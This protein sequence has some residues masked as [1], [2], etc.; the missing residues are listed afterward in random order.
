[1]KTFASPSFFRVFDL[2]VGDTNPGFKQSRWSA[3]GVDFERE[4]HNFS[5]P[6]HEFTIE[7]FTLTK[8]GKRGWSLMV[9]KDYWW[10]GKESDAGRMPHWA[11]LKDGQRADVFAWFRDQELL[12]EQRLS[13]RPQS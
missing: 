9:V 10:A 13:A 3:D 2:L 11:K 12:L 6:R 1:M 4:R 5:G 8:A 7:I